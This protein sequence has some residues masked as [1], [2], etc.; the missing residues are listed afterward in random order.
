M[1][2]NLVIVESPAKAK[3]IEKFLGKDFLVTSSMG[4]IR[5]LEKK[6]AGIDLENNYLPKY[7]VSPDK[8]KIV[9]ELKK[10]AKDAKLVWIASDEDREGEAIAWHLQE[11]LKLKPEKTK[12]IVFHEITKEA[13]LK[14]VDNPRPIDIN[15]VNAQQARRVLDRLVGFEVSPVLWK[16]VKPSLSAGRVQSVAVR[17]I[18]ERE[19]EIIH[20]TATS[21]FRLT[22]VFLVP[23]E[24][25]NVVELKA[26]LNKRFNTKAEAR[27]FLEK[28]QS[29]EFSIADIQKKPSKRT[30]AAPFTTSTLQQEASRKLGFSVS[31]TMSV[32]QRLYE[33]GKITY[34]RTDSVNLS[35]LAI[36]TAKSKILDMHGEKYHKFRQYTTKS[37]GAQEA[38][39]A[40]R[41]TYL[42]QEEVSGTAQE[43]RL[44]ELIWKRTIASQMA[45]AELERTTISIK[46]SNAPEVFQATGEIIKFDGFLRVYLES[47]DNEDEGSESKTLLPPVKVDQLLRAEQID[48]TERFSQKPARYTEASLVKKLEEQGIGRPSTY[49]PTITTIQ[50]RGYVVKEDRPGVERQYATLSLK[51]G[52]LSEK[53]KTEITGAEK[54]KLFPTDIGMV[55]NDFLVKYF[56]KIMDYSFTA[57]VEVDF[58]EI[59]DGKRIWTEVID[60]FYKPFHHHV[61]DALENSERTNGERYLGDDP[62]TGLPV[63][64]KIGRYGPLAQLGETTEEGDKPRFAS[65]RSG[66][67]LE[68]IT[69][70]EALELFKLPRDLGEYEDKKVRV[71]IGRFGPY[72]QHDGKFVSLE[73]N[74]DDPYSVELPRAIELIEAKREKDRKAL[75]KT[76]DEEPELRILEGRWGP[77]ISY[78]KKN[79]KIAKGTDAAALSLEDCMKIIEAGPA[80]KKRGRKK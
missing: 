49:A 19:R 14:A 40:I 79:Y 63:S 10:L 22:A 3:T 47:T 16:K 74:V 37:K 60:A 28:C 68:T 76:F 15:L 31:Q 41:P 54:S 73:K 62:A 50:N 29:A 8:K 48:A 46:V 23:D 59:A 2:E 27:A 51:N 53:E 33:S 30:P 39:E 36:T 6:D 67:I 20:F 34:M 57:N 17:L 44:Y 61:E 11:V 80:P 26:E 78:K 43:K 25:G 35:D 1:Q 66:Q 12:R 65:L 71:N 77:Y 24:N 56:E 21:A 4:H 9:S 75:I 70:E 55:V 58:D 38:H 7:V 13:I 64:V 72:V 5:D 45:D 42:D 69:L 52:K 32:A 18:V